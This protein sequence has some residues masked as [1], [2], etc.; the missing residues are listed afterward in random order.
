MA[1]LNK[2]KNQTLEVVDFDEALAKVEWEIKAYV[3]PV[4]P[5]QVYFWSTDEIL[6]DEKDQIEIQAKIDLE[7]LE[8]AREV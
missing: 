3:L 1:N 4:Q 6:E 8:K 7:Y 2:V 5:E